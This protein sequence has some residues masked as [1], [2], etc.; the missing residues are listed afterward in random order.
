MTPISALYQQPQDNPTEGLTGMLFLGVWEAGGIE[1]MDLTPGFPPCPLIS[2][3]C[4]KDAKLCASDF[5]HNGPC[6]SESFLWWCHTP[7]QSSVPWGSVHM[8]GGCKSS[9]D[10]LI[11]RIL[12]AT[13]LFAPFNLLLYGACHRF[14]HTDLTWTT[15]THD[16]FI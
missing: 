4:L 5:H 13:L 1:K 10:S 3:H 6:K 15:S 2:N 8:S 16:G 9:S 12:F 14:K 11:Q 7:A